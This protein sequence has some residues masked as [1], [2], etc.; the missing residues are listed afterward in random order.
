MGRWASGE[1]RGYP[2]ER[3]SRLLRANR[4]LILSKIRNLN[5]KF[6]Q[7]KKTHQ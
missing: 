3:E 6:C 4:R 5:K 7:V 2:G 1:W